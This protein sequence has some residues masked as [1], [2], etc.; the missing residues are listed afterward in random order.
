MSAPPGTLVDVVLR[1]AESAEAAGLVAYDEAFDAHM[2]EDGRTLSGRFTVQKYVGIW[3]TVLYRNGEPQRSR[4]FDISPSEDLPPDVMLDAGTDTLEVGVDEVFE[5]E[6]QARDDFGIRRVELAIGDQGRNVLWDEVVRRAELLDRVGFTPASLGLQVGDTVDLVVEA[7]DNDTVSGSKV[8]RSQYVQLE[9]LGAKG[10]RDRRA[11]RQAEL[12]ALMVPVLAGFLTETW[13]PGRDAENLLDYGEDLADQYLPVQEAAERL[14]DGMTREG[15]DR[16]HVEKVIATGR[17]LIRYTQLAFSESPNARAPQAE[18]EVTTALREEAVVALENALLAIIRFRQVEALTEVWAQAELLEQSAEN[19]SEMLEQ[20]QL[21][22]QEMLSALDLLERQLGQ[23]MAL[24]AKLESGGLEEFINSREGE[25]KGLMEEIRQAL[26]DGRAEDAKRLMD[27]LQQQLKEMSS[28]IV[29]DLEQ[30]KQQQE[31]SGEDAKDLVKELRDLESEQRKLQKDVQALREKQDDSSAEEVAKAWTKIEL[32]AVRVVADG[33]EYR[34]GLERAKRPF[35][36]RERVG[37]AVESSE[38]LLDAIR[39][40]DL[41]GALGATAEASHQWIVTQST[42]YGLQERAG[43]WK[44]P[45]P[46]VPHGLEKDVAE[47][48]RLLQLLA[49]RNSRMDASSRTQAKALEERQKD[50]HNRLKAAQGEAEDVRKDLAVNPEGMS[51]MLDEASDRMGQA[52]E[53]LQQ[54]K[55]MAAEGSQSVAGERIR[56]AR[57]ALEEAMKQAGG[58]GGSGG[59]QSPSERQQGEDQG[60]GQDSDR[61]GENMQS[62]LEIELPGR[63]AYATPEAYRKALIE[64]MQGEVPDEFRAWK[65]RYY[66]ELVAQ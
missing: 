24:V 18:V 53:D 37:A 64:G 51:E 26:A 34:A 44:G 19:L 46:E 6:W 16:N 2:S 32:L 33:T 7:W 35:Y 30:R 48:E 20:G 40:R 31:Q 29:Q 52:G 22:P 45:S 61:Q 5:L 17:D 11:E 63:D 62:E 27:R 4:D 23:L 38:A 25:M 9:V 58:G 65:K 47:I 66:E 55:A 41:R 60:E 49:S 54:G 1:T 36:E 56:R 42:A 8:G 43:N 14:W 50:L 15:L 59:I 13:P 57:K 39:A 12:E 3:R 10:R 28:G 21:D